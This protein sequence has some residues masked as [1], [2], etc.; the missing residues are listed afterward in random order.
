MSSW[1]VTVS[2]E[3]PA[4]ALELESPRTTNDDWLVQNI[5]VRGAQGGQIVT[6]QIA[7][8][9][10]LVGSSLEAGSGVDEAVVTLGF[11][12]ETTI[13]VF[14]TDPLPIGEHTASL[15]LPIEIKT[16]NE[17]TSEDITVTLT[18][19][20]P[21]AFDD[22]LVPFCNEAPLLTNGNRPTI[23]D[24]DSLSALAED[25]LQEQ[26]RELLLS[27]VTQIRDDLEAFQTGS[28]TEFDTGG[29]N[30]IIGSLCNIDMV[31][32]AVES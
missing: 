22:Q 9:Y 18:Y 3:G 29:A 8:E 31:S 23:Q 1:D 19:T 32:E 27:E 24:L 25:Y 15:E 11:R 17:T 30:G 2:F 13:Q 16:G 6:A 14:V 20:V 12:D 26:D 4:I 7:S 28:G 5:V 21:E 10:T